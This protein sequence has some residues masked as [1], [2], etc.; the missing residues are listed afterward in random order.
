MEHDKIAPNS[1]KN[2]RLLQIATTTSLLLTTRPAM[3]SLET[4]LLKLYLPLIG[5]V[6]LGL[7]LGYRLPKRVIG[8]LGKFLFWIGVPISITAFLRGANLSGAIWIA[9][10]AA[11]AAILLGAGLALLWLRGRSLLSWS[12]A[13]QGSF[14]LAAMVGN[15]GY[16]GYP[17]TLTLVG[18]EYFGWALFYDLLGT[19][20]GAYGLG[21]AIAAKFGNGTQ[22]YG[23]LWQALLQNPALWSLGWGLILRNYPLPPLVEHTLTQTA[24]AIVA[25][26][27]MLIGMRLSQL[28]SWSSLPPAILTLSL[29]M[30]LVP[31]VLG[32][33]LSL[34]GFK[35][36]PQ[37]VIVLQMAMPPAFATLVI[38]EA[39]ELDRDLAV[40]ALAIGSA[41]LLV[42]LPF[43][44]WLFG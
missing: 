35:G 36:P 34:A 8:Y 23:W 43:W 16:L 3:S 2:S 4:N 38:A 7:L 13:T 15:T 33:G 28:S 40:T 14:L 1:I 37:L 24:W 27:L 26:S 44:L 20:L 19:T 10:V 18:T 31:L 29:K 12:R 21:V 39:Y 6:L 17:V 22:R 9:P 5:W 30:L 42:L 32:F 25:L 11:W 41:G